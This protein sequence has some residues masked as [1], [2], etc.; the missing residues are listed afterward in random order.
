MKLFRLRT[1]RNLPSSLI[2]CFISPSLTG[3]SAVL[4][5]G[6]VA[7]EWQF[8]CVAG[9]LVLDIDQRPENTWGTFFTSF[10]LAAFICSLFES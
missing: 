7:E 3:T 10:D 9:F 6:V 8:F 5:I 2:A 1:V 4:V